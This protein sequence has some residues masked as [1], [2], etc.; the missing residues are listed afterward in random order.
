MLR[1]LLIV[2]FLS[3]GLLGSEAFAVSQAEEYPPAPPGI[4]WGWQG[5]VL[6]DIDSARLHAEAKALLKQSAELL[7]QNPSVNILITGH[8]D[9]TGNIEYNQQL[10]IKRVTAVSN[11]LF[12]R[13][14]HY[15]RI[16][17]HA[18]G[19]QRP[20]SSN[21]CP[22]DRSRNRRADLAFFPNGY[23]P[24]YAQPIVNETQPQAGECEQAREESARMQPVPKY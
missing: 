8:T 24:Q 20:V 19:E 17:T 9:N 23:Q 14:I 3:T 5:H 16:I 15:S 10:S 4:R 12:K 13:G 22:E 6:F 21:A 1:K 11:Y 2:L 7:R 18:T